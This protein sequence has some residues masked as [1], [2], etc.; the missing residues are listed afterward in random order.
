MR[1]RFPYWILSFVIVFLYAPLAIL[2]LYSFNAAAGD[3]WTGFS[4]RWYRELFFSSPDLWR[5]FGNTLLIAVGAGV[6]ATILGTAGAIGLRWSRTRFRKALEGISFLPMVT[7]EIII[8]VS[9]LLLFAGLRV[10]LSL[11]TVLLAHITFCLPFTWLI[12]TA[13]L[14]EFDRSVLEAA[15]DLGANEWQ[16]LVRVILPMAL[17]GILSAFLMAVTLS[18]EDFV[19]TFFVSGPG[20]STL[21]VHIYGMMRLGVTPVINALSVLLLAGTAVLAFLTRRMVANLGRNG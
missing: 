2:S 19:I 10:P 20:S 15:R 8:G 11:F 9:L 3:A 12:V 17:P 13:R 14:Q 6:F 1:L 7:P 5:S 4:L 18:M 21:A 16:T